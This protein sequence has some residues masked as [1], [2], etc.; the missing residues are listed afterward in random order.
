MSEIGLGAVA[1]HLSLSRPVGR[2]PR[3]IIGLKMDAAVLCRSM[4]HVVLWLGCSEVFRCDSSVE[5][6][7]L[8]SL[9]MGFPKD[10]SFQ[11]ARPLFFAFVFGFLCYQSDV[12]G[13]GMQALILLTFHDDI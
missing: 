12:L 6:A 10:T 5:V 3:E 11:E 2:S 4:G 8:L 13:V 7:S 9:P 1:E